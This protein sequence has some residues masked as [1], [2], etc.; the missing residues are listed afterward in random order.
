MIP[1]YRSKV[2]WECICPIPKQ[3]EDRCL[4]LVRIVRQFI[5]FV[6]TGVMRLSK[7]RRYGPVLHRSLPVGA[8]SIK[9]PPLT[10]VWSM[11]IWSCDHFII[12]VKLC[13]ASPAGASPLPVGQKRYSGCGTVLSQPSWS[14]DHSPLQ[15]KLCR[16]PA[17]RPPGLTG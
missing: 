12:Q 15:M 13:R 8:R 2:K 16:A 1:H 9:I 14:C 5:L 10:G 4:I 3:D 11:G 7:E 6:G 17:V